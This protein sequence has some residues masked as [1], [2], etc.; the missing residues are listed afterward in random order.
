MIIFGSGGHTSEMLRLLS[1]VSANYEPR[2]YVM[3]DTDKMSQ[4]KIIKL[5]TMKKSELGN[6]Y[7]LKRIPRSREVHQSWVTTVLTTVNA[8][9]HAFPMVFKAL[10]DLVLC[11]GPGTCIPLCAAA[12]TL[13]FLGVKKVHVVY[14]ES[15]CRVDSLSLSGKILYYFAD[16]LFVQWPELL[17]AYPKSIYV[18]RIV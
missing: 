9:F 1:G 4:E 11:N 14:V 15:I 12:L 18:G 2:I 5:E 10:P 3:A 17:K 16:K 8:T 7:M 13:T 6:Q